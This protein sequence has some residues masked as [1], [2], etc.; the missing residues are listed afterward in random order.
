M[1]KF[2]WKLKNT[3]IGIV[4]CKNSIFFGSQMKTTETYIK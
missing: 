3:P 4:K 2:M 1:G